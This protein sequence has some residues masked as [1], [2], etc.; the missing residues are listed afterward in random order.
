MPHLKTLLLPFLTWCLLA[1][2]LLSG[3]P[4]RIGGEYLDRT[5]TRA[6]TTYALARGLNGAISVAQATEF[7]VEPLGIGFSLKPIT[8]F[9]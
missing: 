2:L 6:L 5:L 4:D 1:A 3:M 7:S 8:F 9:P